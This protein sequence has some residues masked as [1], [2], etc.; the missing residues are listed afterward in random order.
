M[1]DSVHLIRFIKMR[2]LKN[3]YSNVILIPPQ[4]GGRRIYSFNLRRKTRFFVATLL[5]MT[6]LRNF[7]E[8]SKCQCLL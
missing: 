4:N 5:R 3:W 7:S 2:H 8:V 1:D 6:L